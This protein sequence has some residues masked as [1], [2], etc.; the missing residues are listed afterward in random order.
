VVGTSWADPE[1][2]GWDVHYKV[3]AL[4]FV[5][6]ESEP[7]SAE[8]TT[9]VAGRA[10]PRTFGLYPT[11]P[12]PFNPTT[13]IRYDVPSG[14]GDVT[15]SV[16]DVTGALVLTLVDGPQTAGQKAVT[17][18]GKDSRGRSVASGVY[19]YELRAPGYQKTLKMVLVK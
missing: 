9:A 5:G 8:V 1:Y 11:V 13:S 2:D 16:Y 17:W 10:I 3:T 18:N 6:N 4:D 19:F 15:I 14:G 12:N 7:A